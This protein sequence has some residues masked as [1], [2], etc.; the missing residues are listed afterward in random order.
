MG[1]KEFN[2][3]T[4]IYHLRN[5]IHRENNLWVWKNIPAE[6]KYGRLRYPRIGTVSVRR[7]QRGLTTQGI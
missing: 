5:T 1:I 2:Q 6:T 4:Q 3:K 7:P